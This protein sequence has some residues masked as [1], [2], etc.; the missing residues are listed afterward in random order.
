MASLVLSVAGSAIG[1]ALFDGFTVFGAT[2]TGAQIGG[3]IGTLIGAEIDSALMPGQ[4]ISRSGP[5]LSDVN[6]QASTEGAAI[7]RVYGRLRVA[8]QILWASQ[9]KETQTTTKTGGGKGGGGT[10]VTETDY[11]YSIS[12]AVGLCAGVVT[13]I[14]RV[15]ADGNLIDLGAFT[16]RFYAG[17]E[18]QGFDPGIEDI[19]GD[20]NTPAY[21]GVA[22]IVFD[23][24]PLAQFGNRIPQLQFEII[25]SLSANDPLSLENTLGGVALIPGAGEFV[26]ASTVITADDGD[27]TTLV[28][29]AH[30][31]ASEADIDASLDE[32]QALAPN[33]RAVSLVVGWFGSDLRCEDCTIM[34]G[35]ETPTK[36]TYPE[37]WSVDG[38]LRPAAHLVSQVNGIPAYG[39]TPSD[40]SV[41]EAIANLKARGLAVMLCPF[42]FMD[43]ASGNTLTDPYTGLSGQGAYPW[44]GRITCD[45]APGVSGS[46]DKTSTAATQTAAFFGNAAASDFSVEGTTVA[47]HGGADWGWRRMVLHY[48][49]LAE[50]AGGVDA[51][52]IG[53]ELRGL[54]HVRDSAVTYPAVAALKTLAADV[55]AILGGGTKIGYAADW[56][57]YNNHQTGDASGAL[58]FNLDPLWSDANIDFVGID[59]YLPLADWRDGT[60]GLDYDAVHGPTSIYDLGYLTGNIRGGE[61]YDWYYASLGD[62]DTQTR[63]PITDGLGKPWVWRA[64]DFWNWWSNAHYDRPDGHESATPTA[65]VPQ[66][67][68]IW[69]C[70]LGCPAI[71]KGA[72]QPNVFYDPKSSESALP[73][74]SNGERDDLIQRLFLQAQLNFWSDATNN[75]AIGGVKMV[76]TTRIFAWCWDARPFP[77]FPALANVWGDAADYQFGHWLNGRLGAV[78][79]SDLVSGLCADASFTDADV[80]NL[81]GIVTG[82]AVTDTMSPRDAITPL[83]LAYHF[84]GVESAG[85]IRFVMRGRPNPSSYGESDLVIPDGDPS[86]GFSLERAQETDLPVASRITYIDADADYRQAVAEARRL[87]GSSDRVASSSLPIV[88]DQGQ[89]IGIGQSLLMDAWVM[90][91][92]A[93]FALPPSSL[94]LDPTDEVW[95]TC[96]GR[97]R[98]LRLT[99][100]DDATQRKIDAVATD[101]SVYEPITGPMRSP[102]A[103]QSGTGQPGKALVEF[104]DLPLLTGNEVPW[105]P[106][107]AAFAN[108]WPG[109]VMVLKS[110]G[111][112]NY[113]LDTQ[114]TLAAQIGETTA[115]FHGGPA[116]RWDDANTLSLRL[117][118]GACASLDDLSVLGGANALAIEN[119]DGEWEVL[120]YASATLT[121]P[122]SWGLTRLLRGQAG[123]EGAMRNPVAAG[124]RVVVLDR[125]LSQLALKQD[126]YALAFNYLWGPKGKAISDPAYQGAALQFTGVGLRPLSPVQL[127][128]V[129]QSGDLALSW[130]RRTRIGG[131]SW[132]QTDVPLAEDVE[133]Y[134][135]DVLDGSGAVVRTLSAASGAITYSAADIAA[136]FP[137]GLPT[138][139]RFT[140]YQ[141][142]ATYGR[143]V[144][145]TA[146]ISLSP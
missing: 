103:G 109:A 12:F 51:F 19:E 83:G 5:R 144:G 137:S 3:A 61:D 127:R 32:L 4:N 106:H 39:G 87:V 86:F 27:G 25:R 119:A 122:K 33:L 136:D 82:F 17:D 108:P 89:A 52:L 111:D 43:I 94:A 135:V 60:V 99:G 112:S 62:R 41:V 53:S 6:I 115:D 56:S 142:S 24:M 38:V 46:P 47:W 29:N 69:F 59:N 131:D 129:W 139:F 16:T 81:S 66:S 57:E 35:V 120:Q 116:W 84:D 14:G 75:P 124:A 101:P 100:I 121:A 37:L 114:L 78:A 23:D 95:L 48:A 73:Y 102:G 134:E 21:R 26:Y 77:F 22:Y 126:E 44:R 70:E 28:Q 31:S 1:S 76:D 97:T 55:R 50:A 54:T 110:A 128:A 36:D 49:L 68:P 118:N 34:P 143:G 85:V 30:N 123:T 93:S 13:K 64:K 11:T 140:V 146:Q 8:G 104:L 15:W 72:N 130:T 10:T 91:E 71:D 7:P 40:A 132:D 92:S 80:S 133:A 74:Y 42:L 107:V 145:T 105:A 90:R 18:A 65:W 125:A 20:G 9:Y 79:L 117:Y 98:R 67:K 2:I 88:L 58:L 138:P 45:P 96:G 63:T 113:A 141:L